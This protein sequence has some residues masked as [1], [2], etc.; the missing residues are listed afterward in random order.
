MGV[1]CWWLQDRPVGTQPICPHGLLVILVLPF[2]CS[3]ARPHGG[4]TSRTEWV[5]FSLGSCRCQIL[6][7][8][9][10]SSDCSNSFTVS[11][12]TPLNE[13]LFKD[14]PKNTHKPHIKAC[15]LQCSNWWRKKHNPKGSVNEWTPCRSGEW[16]WLRSR[17]RCAQAE[18]P[19]GQ[20]SLQSGTISFK[21]AASTLQASLV[22]I[23]KDTFSNVGGKARWPCHC[24]DQWIVGPGE[25]AEDS[26]FS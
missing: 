14:I 12:L 17:H 1:C 5:P 6:A 13:E 9:P 3:W 22:F 11:N 20:A 23:P 26:G 18:L 7:P 21:S 10:P 19:L 15:Q 25:H 4:G 8:Q 2:F 16:G 24:A